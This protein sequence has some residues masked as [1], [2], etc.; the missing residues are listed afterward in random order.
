[1][2]NERVSGPPPKCKTR[3]LLVEGTDIV[4][5]VVGKEGD[6]REITTLRELKA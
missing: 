2:G 4:E 1:M 6:R 5:R 3:V